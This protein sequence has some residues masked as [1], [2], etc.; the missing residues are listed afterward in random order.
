MGNLVD[1]SISAAKRLAQ[2]A[3]PPVARWAPPQFLEAQKISAWSDM[4][5]WQPASGESAAFAGTSAKRAL[6]A[7]LSVRPMLD[8][9]NDTLA[10]HLQRPAAERDALKAGLAAD[11]ETAALAALATSTR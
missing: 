1:T 11:R 3:A 10:W 2:P 8:T 9:V 6:A 4:P 5:V 7:G